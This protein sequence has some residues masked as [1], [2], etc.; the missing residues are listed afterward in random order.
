MRYK[1]QMLRVL[2]G[3]MLVITDYEHP[4]KH[5][6]PRVTSHYIRSGDVPADDLVHLLGE[7]YR[8]VAE[9]TP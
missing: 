3:T 5:G 2:D 1:V 8:L 7:L 6:H 4:A 9:V